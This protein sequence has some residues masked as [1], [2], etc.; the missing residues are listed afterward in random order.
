MT[1]LERLNALPRT[2]ALEEFLECCGS[3]VWAET[4]V[5]ARPFADRKALLET[6][7]NLWVGLQAEDWLEAFGAHPRI[8][9]RALADAREREARWSEQEQAGAR[10]ADSDTLAE[11]AEMNRTYEARFGHI[12]LISATGRSAEEM[13]TA[14]RARLD[15]DAATE[16][17]MAAEEQ[18]K[19]TRLRLEKLL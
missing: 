1:G 2:A 19:I 18:R 4:M 13:L 14:L 3:Q 17:G 10:D 5:D 6:A 9:E 8:G 11:L 15:N 12:F 7:D 16:L